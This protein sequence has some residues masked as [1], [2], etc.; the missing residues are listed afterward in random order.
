MANTR[1]LHPCM[2]NPDRA[3]LTLQQAKKRLFFVSPFEHLCQR[4]KSFVFSLNLFF[5]Q[6]TVGFGNVQITA[7]V[8]EEKETTFGTQIL[9]LTRIKK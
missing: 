7:K 2:A 8:G 9:I 6:G 3:F 5:I 4:F 1:D